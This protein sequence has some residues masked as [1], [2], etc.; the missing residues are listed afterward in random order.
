MHSDSFQV[1]LP[2]VEKILKG[3]VVPF[4]TEFRASAAGFEL[5]KPDKTLVDVLFRFYDMK[6]HF[7]KTHGDRREL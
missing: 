7:F 2:A 4:W 1:V 3:F 6:M 5:R